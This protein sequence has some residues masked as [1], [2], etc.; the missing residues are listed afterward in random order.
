[1]RNIQQLADHWCRPGWPATLM[2]V[3][4]RLRDLHARCIDLPLA[5]SPRAAMAAI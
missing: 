3:G 2:R 4:L 1:M 5:Q